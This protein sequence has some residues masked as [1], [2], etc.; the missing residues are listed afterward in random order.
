MKRSYP[1]EQAYQALRPMM[2]SGDPY[3]AAAATKAYAAIRQR[4]ST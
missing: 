2:E 1:L 4:L 3:Q